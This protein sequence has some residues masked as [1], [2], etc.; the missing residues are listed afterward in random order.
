VALDGS[1]RASFTTAALATGSHVITAVYSGN[2]AASNSPTLTQT[3]AACGAADHL[4]FVQQPTAT[5]AGQAINSPGGVRVEVVDAFGNLVTGDLSK[6]TVSVASGP[7]TFASGTTT[8]TVSKGIAAFTNLVLDTAG[9]YTLQ[10]ADG[11]LRG[12]VSSSFTISAAAAT[13][14][15]VTVTGPVTAGSSTTLT[16]TALDPF[17]NVATG[18][19]GTVFFS[20]SDCQAVLPPNAT[21]VSGTGTFAVTF[22]TP[23]CQSVSATDTINQAITGSAAV[24]VAALDAAVCALAKEWAAV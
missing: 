16:V 2:R 6:V 17:G 21:L 1:G 24:T 15:R 12:A 19:H 3:V 13:C 18:Y 8:L 5:T 7:G 23:G 14:F 4:I 20:S 22:N 10:V 9:T 11:S